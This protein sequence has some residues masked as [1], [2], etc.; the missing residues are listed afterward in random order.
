MSKPPDVDHAKVEVLLSAD[1]I[2][3]RVREL[4]EEISRDYGAGGVTMVGILKGCF[5]FFSDLVRA[6]DIPLRTEFIGISSYGDETSST[7]VVKITSDL[8]QP[9]EGERVL[10]VE[11]II[12]T[13]LT[14]QY[15]LENFATRQPAELKVCSLLHKP[16]RTLVEVRRDYVGFTIE[17]AF[18]VGY[19]LDYAQYYR[20]L[21]YVGVY[22]G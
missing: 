13:G 8:T 10:I 21:P 6:C 14:M 17:D 12:D 7:G 16:A 11:D 4:G 19:G 20:N 15:L 18:V 3:A 1:Q 5:V 22:R 9:I 2:R